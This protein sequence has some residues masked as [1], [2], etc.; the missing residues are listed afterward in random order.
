MATDAEGPVGAGVGDG[1]G[2][3]DVAGVEEPLP[4]ATANIKV[5]DTTTKHTE[6]IR[7]SDLPKREDPSNIPGWMEMIGTATNA[8]GAEDAQASQGPS[9]GAIDVLQ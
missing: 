4:Q 5:A 2:E 8:G 7:S 1:V 3:G 9:H 6:R